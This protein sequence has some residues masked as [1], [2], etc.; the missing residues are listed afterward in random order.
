MSD[1]FIDFVR[2]RDGHVH[3]DVDGTFAYSP[4]R[5]VALGGQAATARLALF[6]N[7]A[8]AGTATLTGALPGTLV[9]VYDALGRKVTSATADAAGTAVLVLPAGLPVGVYVV[10]AGSKALRLTVE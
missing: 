3:V 7:P 9:S 10:R 4:V 2:C 6:P 1:S 5:S 8:Q